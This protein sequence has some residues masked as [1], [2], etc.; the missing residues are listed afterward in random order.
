MKAIVTKVT[1]MDKRDMYNN[2]SFKIELDNGDS[3]F[4]TSKNEDQTKFVVG[5]EAE[6]NI[7]KKIGKEGKEY[8][9]ITLPQSDKS[10]G[11]RPQVDPKTQ[12]ISFS[13]SY[14]KDLVVAGKVD[15][16]DI[17]KQFDI[18]YTLMISKL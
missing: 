6:Y 7:E 12:M 3:G 14:C 11:G 10:F 17:G 13:M 5:K 8:F 15:I 2:T 1:K 16:K 18:I 9:K 4:Y